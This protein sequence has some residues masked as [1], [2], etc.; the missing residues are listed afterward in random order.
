MPDEPD[1]DALGPME[2]ER[3]TGPGR[4]EKVRARTTRPLDDEIAA[5]Q[6]LPAV[7]EVAEPGYRPPGLDVRAVITDTLFT[8][9]VRPSAL[10]D[11]DRDPRVV[12]IE[13]GSRL[14]QI[15]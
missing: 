11:L 4:Y 15:E 9:T 14:D 12:S 2:I 6:P 13:L 3:T 1:R 7:V 5:D 10:A 8:A